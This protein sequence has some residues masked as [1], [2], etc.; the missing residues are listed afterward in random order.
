MIDLPRR[1]RWI[2][3]AS[4]AAALAGCG[5]PTE[6]A[7]RPEQVTDFR[8]LY[9]ENCAGCHGADG[10]RG[11]AQPLNDPVY[12][13]L[14]S[15]A[16]LIDVISHGMRGTPMTPFAVAAGGTLTDEQVRALVDGIRRNWSGAQRLAAATAPAYSE[17]DAIAQGAQRGDPTRGR[18]TYETYCGRCHGNDGRGGP[19]AGSVVDE[20]FLS[21]TSNQA[22]RTT[23]LA[24]R[25]DENIPG[26]R[27]YVPGQPM[28]SQQ[29][30]D[31]VAWLVSHRGTHD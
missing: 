16:R 31:V 27:D 30:S 10:R 12:L 1:A 11:V 13:A 20:A 9:E 8:I 21:L 6:R 3:F 4:F 29:V 19:T 25:A 5:R 14:V 15:D 22:L 2:V 17:D 7:G 23:I 18:A 28:T 24:G 26:W